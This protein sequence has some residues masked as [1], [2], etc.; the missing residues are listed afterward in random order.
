MNKWRD[1]Y[2]TLDESE[3]DGIDVNAAQHE[4]SGG[5]TKDQAEGRAHQDYLRNH[6]LD[7]AAWHYLG[8]KAA[9]AVHNELAGKRHGAA[10]MLALKC[11]GLD[12]TES[13][14]KE[15]LDRIKSLR[16]NPYSFKAH[17]A[18]ELFG[19]QGD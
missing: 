9:I 17:K 1:L 3:H 10:Y 15:V 8:M 2:P 14:S 6:A 13:P 5:M 18:D 19:S 11:L 16:E 4:F 7:S 12:A